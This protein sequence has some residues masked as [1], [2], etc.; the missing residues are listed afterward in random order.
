MPSVIMLSAI[1]MIG[2]MKCC[3]FS[4][5]QSVI[6]LSVIALIAVMIRGIMKCA[7]LVLGR[8][9]LCCVSCH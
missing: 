5:R 1:M 4:V 6:M 8:V 3:T 7:L 2:I 9:S